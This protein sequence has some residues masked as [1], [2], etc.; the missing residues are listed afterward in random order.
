[1]SYTKL[2][3]EIERYYKQNNMPFSYNALTTT[4]EEQAEILKKYN[5]VRDII[6]KKWIDEKRYKELISCAHGRWFP[7]NEFTKP[8]AEYFIKENLI[9]H[10]KFLCEQEIRFKIEDLISVLETA[11]EDFPELNMKEILAFDLENYANKGGNYNPVGEVMR[12]RADSLEVLDRYIELLKTTNETEYLKMIESL[13]EKV[14]VL[15]IKKS[16]TKYIK[17]KF[18]Q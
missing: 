15:T 12:W 9:S 13:R 1:M 8:L 10:L 16:D 2:D 18:A 7:Y 14:S 11:Y 5:Q 6:V 4:K 17:N 3:K